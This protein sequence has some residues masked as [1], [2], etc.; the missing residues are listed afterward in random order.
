MPPLGLPGNQG[1]V[2][3]QY[4]TAAAMSNGLVGSQ[5]HTFPQQSLPSPQPFTPPIPNPEIPNI[6]QWF[7]YLDQDERRNKDGITFAPYGAT[8]KAKGFLR[9]SQLT[10]EFVKLPDL[11]AWLGIEVGTVIL[12]LEYAKEDLAA[13]KSGRWVFPKDV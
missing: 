3:L 1:P 13:I 8:L 6:V 11:Q 12:I 7:K 10:S 9:I 5:S 2:G 4:G